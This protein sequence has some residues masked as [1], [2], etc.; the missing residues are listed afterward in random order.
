MNKRQQLSILLRIL[1]PG[2]I[3]VGIMLGSFQVS[4]ASIKP[5]TSH[6]YVQAVVTEILTDYSGGRPFNGAQTV[7]ARITSGVWKGQQV[8]LSNSNSYQQGAFCQ[9]GTKI[10]AVVQS[11]AD[12]SLN[13][14]VYNY[15][16][17]GMVYALA[18]L[19]VAG[20][21]LVGGRKGFATLWALVFTFGC[22]AF[23][24]R[25]AALPWCERYLG[26]YAD[27]SDDSG[28]VALHFKRLVAQDA[29]QY[30]RYNAGGYDLRRTGN[31]A[32]HRR[33]FERLPRI[34]R[35]VNGLHRQ[36]VGA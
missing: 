2:V 30:L 34:G 6:S 31:A 1:L 28:S 4:R 12:G 10:V 32:G 22:V 18:A 24:I 20:L 13:G 9:V 29:V 35:G 25:A 17:T 36:C 5:G 19:F 16:R 15:D 33:T 8:T 14:S 3:L 11:G 23:F 27:G 7:A 26:W 21:V